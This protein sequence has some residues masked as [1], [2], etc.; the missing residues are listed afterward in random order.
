MQH[1]DLTELDGGLRVVSERLE[2]VRSVAVGLWI[3]VGSRDET[4]PRRG[5]S[6]FIEHMLFKG[7]SRHDALA[8]A[9]VFDSF[10][11]EL[12]AAT[13]KDHTMLYTRVLDTHVEAALDVMCDM[14]SSPVWAELEAEREVVLEEIAMYHDDPQELVHDLIAEA[15]FGADDPLGTPV[16]GTEEVIRGVD[17]AQVAAFH[18]ERYTAPNIVVSAA[19]HIEHA[20]ITELAGSLL[21]RLDATAPHAS[22][23]TGVLDGVQTPR[24]VFLE[25]ETEQVP[26]LPGRAGPVAQRPAALR[27][28]PARHDARRER[29][30]APLPGDP[31][32]ARHGL[33]RSTA[34][35]RTTPRRDRSASTWARAPRTS[36]SACAWCASRSASWP[37]A[38]FGDEEL[39]RAR[40]NLKGRVLLSMELTSARMSRLGRSVLAGT[41]IQSLDRIAAEIDAVEREHVAD[42]AD[43]LFAPERLSAAGIGADAGLYDEALREISEPHPGSG[44]IAVALAGATGKTGACLAD[45]LDAAADIELVA[46][47]APS[48]AGAGP[49]ATAR[50]PTRSRRCA[51]TS[52]WSSRAPMR[53]ARTCAACLAAGR[54]RGDRHDGPR[55]QPIATRW[56]PRRAPPACRSSGP[57]TT[58]STAVL[59]MRFA[60]EAARYVPRAEVVE[61]HSE[62][63]LDAPSAHGRRDGRR[64]RADHG[65]RRAGALGAP[66]RPRGA[67]GGALRRRRGSCSRSATTRTSREAF[68]PGVLL[69]VRALRDLPPGLTAGLEALL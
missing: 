28:G 4:R 57:P 69:A 23:R 46:R 49:G 25:K 47:I 37:R 22:P 26:R 59:M 9:Q 19:G 3:G 64:D 38:R 31:R 34:T 43:R 65:R 55:R 33:L 54:A 42:L 6:H 53:C 61:L 15:V 14:V 58:R 44:V 12:N 1:F 62:H 18:A 11:G 60:R 24:R 40:E 39:E 13:S 17:R 35:A 32:A 5:L 8:I 10:G 20:H 36:S 21:A 63:K 50:S 66:A 48:L 30:L 52:R 68:A 2:T 41:E 51:R 16:I 7:A 45:A 27:G 67:P 56:T 29:V